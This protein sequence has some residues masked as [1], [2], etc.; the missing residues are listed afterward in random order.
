MDSSA[1]PPLDARTVPTKLA[2]APTSSRPARSREISAPTSKSSCWTRVSS[3]GAADRPDA[4]AASTGSAPRDR[5]EEGDFRAVAQ[6][7]R[8]IGEHLVDGVLR[9]V[10]EETGIETRFVELVGFRHWHGYRFGKS[11]IYF[12][13]RLDPLTEEIRVQESEIEMCMWMP[14]GDYLAA[15]SVGIFNKRMVS[16]ALGGTG[17]RR[18]W[19]EGYGAPETHE[20]FLVPGGDDER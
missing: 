13:C 15:E 17:L 8:R 16:T 3:V 12:I 6:G 7:R 14:L 1:A 5:R 20:I 11:D 19:F 4:P 18:G 9:E 10:R 2:T